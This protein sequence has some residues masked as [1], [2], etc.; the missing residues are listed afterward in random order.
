MGTVKMGKDSQNSIVNS[1]GQ[2]HAIENLFVVD[3]SIFVTSGA[4]NP[5]ASAQALTL[6]C[7]EYIKNNLNNLIALE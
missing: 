7:C 6:R 5:V 3:S 2:S 4:V 1:F